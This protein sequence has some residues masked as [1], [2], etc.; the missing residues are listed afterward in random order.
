MCLTDLRLL[1]TWESPRQSPWLAFDSDLRRYVQT[2]GQ[3]NV[4]VRSVDD[5]RV[6][7]ELPGVSSP[8]QI[9][10]LALSVD[11]RYLSVRHERQPG[12]QLSV[13]DLDRREVVLRVPGGCHCDFSADGRRAA[14]TRS[15][16]SVGLC[17]LSTSKEVENLAP[18]RSIRPHPGTLCFF[19]E[20]S[21]KLAIF[22]FDDIEVRIWDFQS[23]DPARTLTC[24]D[25]VEALAWHPAG[26]MLAIGDTGTRIL[27]WD[28]EADRP[29]KVLEG[30]D[31]TVTGLTFNRSGDLLGSTSYDGTICL[32]DSR[33]GKLLV[34][35][36]GRGPQFSADGN[37][38][39]VGT[40]DGRAVFE[41]NP[42]QVYH[43]LHHGKGIGTSVFPA[44][45]PDGRLLATASVDGV[46]ITDLASRAEVGWL[47]I[48]TTYTV[49]FDPAGEF[50]F[51]GGMAGMHRWRLA[52]GQ[53]P[54]DY[55]LRV[56][57]PRELYPGTSHAV[58]SW[59]GKTLLVWDRWQH[60]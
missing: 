25:P 39:A 26:Q 34:R 57:P 17:D 29:H 41:L 20:Q 38:L 31:L 11:G 8:G 35:I 32:W 13:W 7:V 53:K 21:S 52:R 9:G 43:S 33:V 16:G 51:T 18:G 10:S 44:V 37:R 28:L 59:D 36:P 49:H 54:G 14:V 24:P 60:A 58:P 30:H 46:R 1:R 22:H 45:S 48:G 50:L 40:P 47:E 3:G 4:I 5:D 27:L 56:G 55:G 42:G 23:A 19:N 2:D 15:D 12:T 6:L